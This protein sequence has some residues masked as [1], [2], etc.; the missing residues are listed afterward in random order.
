MNRKAILEFTI[1]LIVLF[2]TLAYFYKCI[3]DNHSNEVDIVKVD[4]KG[5]VKAPGV[6]YMKKG[7][8]M[9]EVINQCGGFTGNSSLPQEFDFAAPLYEDITIIIPKAYTFERY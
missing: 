3:S 7:S 5:S 6:Y 8:V 1:I 9:S 4:I 2:C